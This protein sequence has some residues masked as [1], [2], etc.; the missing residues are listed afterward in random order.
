MTKKSELEKAID[1]IH[2]PGDGA[3]LVSGHGFVTRESALSTLRE[4]L[5]A[6][7]RFDCSDVWGMEETPG[8]D[9]LRLSDVLRELEGEE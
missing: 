6:L 8:G 1:T 9:W 3:K 4:R 7:P 5:M 2:N